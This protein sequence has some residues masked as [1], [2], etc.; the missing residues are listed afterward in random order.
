M[1]RARALAQ[2]EVIEALVASFQAAQKAVPEIPA[3][4]LLALRLIDGL[5]Q[6][7]RQVADISGDTGTQQQNLTSLRKAIRAQGQEH[8]EAQQDGT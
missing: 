8:K 5:E 3:K 6:L 7:Y 4:Q 2:K 1:G